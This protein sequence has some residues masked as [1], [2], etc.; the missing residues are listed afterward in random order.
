MASKESAVATAKEQIK[1]KKSVAET[2]NGNGEFGL[3][4]QVAIPGV[5]RRTDRGVPAY[6]PGAG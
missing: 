3:G 4:W 6:R 2:G 1:P 5:A